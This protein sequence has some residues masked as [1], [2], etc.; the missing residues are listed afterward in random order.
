MTDRYY[1]KRGFTIVELLIVIVIIGVLAT[2]TVVAYNGVQQNARDKSVLSDLDILDGVETEYGLKN[3]VG[4]KAWYSG[5]GIDSELN[6]TPSPGNIVDVV[7]SNSDYCI[8]GYNANSS[9]NSIYNAATKE[10]STGVCSVRGPSIAAGGSASPTAWWK[11]NGDATDSS[12]NGN[13]G[14]IVGATPTTGQNGL[15]NGAYSFNGTSDYITVPNSTSLQLNGTFTVSLWFK[16]NN[17]STRYGL[18]STRT[19]N[20]NGGWQLEAG[21]GNSGSG[22]VDITG[23]GTWILQSNNNIISSGNWYNAVYVKPGNGTQGGSLYLNG[24]LPTP[25]ATTAYVISD[26]SDQKRI[27]VGTSSTQ[28]FPG[29]IDDVRIYNYAL[30]PADVSAIYSA[31]AQ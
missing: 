24:I 20:A 1:L 30:S 27:G 14:T 13:N 11:M 16:A 8:R 17:L 22:Q 19:N 10:S 2:I 28:Y 29:A 31:G 26:N 3:S 5:N 15:S 6:F 12:G 21:V 25:A 18:F 7:I 9:Y 4:G 23:V